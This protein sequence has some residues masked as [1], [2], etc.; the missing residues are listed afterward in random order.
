M[1][2]T[3]KLHFSIFLCYVWQ[4]IV[5]CDQRNLLSTH[6]IKVYKY[7]SH[8]QIK[9]YQCK[10]HLYQGLLIQVSPL[11]SLLIQ[12]THSLRFINTSYIYIKV[13]WY[14]LH[15][16]KGLLIQVTIISK[17]MLQVLLYTKVWSIQ[18]TLISRFV[19]ISYIMF[20]WSDHSIIRY[21]NIY[22]ECYTN[23]LS[24]YYR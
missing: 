22:F 19:N 2:K 12:V 23:M 11:L 16:F 24:F 21:Q 9:V 3:Q 14:K 5:S 10:L 20:L 1:S 13:Y 7:K 15:L 18:D 4:L 17:F 8:I 6:D